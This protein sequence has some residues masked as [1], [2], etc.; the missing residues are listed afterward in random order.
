MY[1]CMTYVSRSDAIKYNSQTQTHNVG[2][3]T[4]LSLRVA[5]VVQQP[6]IHQSE[7]GMEMGSIYTH[8]EGVYWM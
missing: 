5:I 8:R 6:R 4:Y 7:G 3:P 1:V 2:A